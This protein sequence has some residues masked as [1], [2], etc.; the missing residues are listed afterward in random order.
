MVLVLNELLTLTGDKRS[1][2]KAFKDYTQRESLKRSTDLPAGV[3]WTSLRVVCESIKIITTS[4][5]Q[6]NCR[7][8][9]RTGIELDC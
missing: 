2:D 5:G 4:T 7:G 3:D 8:S 1:A 6:L 9:V